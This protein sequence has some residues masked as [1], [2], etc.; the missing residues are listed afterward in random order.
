LKS[1]EFF[2]PA[3]DKTANDKTMNNK[4]MNDKIMNKIRR[5]H[6]A[7]ARRQW[8]KRWEGGDAMEAATS[9]MRAQQLILAAVEGALTPFSLTFARY[10]ALT[11]LSF[12]KT[13]ALPLGKMGQRLMIHAASVT[14][15]VDRLEAQGFVE[16]RAHP[17]DRRTTLCVI[18]DAGREVVTRA[19][20]AVV[21]VDLGVGSLSARERQQLITIVRKLRGANGDDL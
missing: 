9:I 10:E 14:N 4:I 15:I 2:M 20:K 5:D 6:L 16:R 1:E 13:G 19:T 11:L 17:D 18:T 7:E 21:A 8:D 3:N 12:T